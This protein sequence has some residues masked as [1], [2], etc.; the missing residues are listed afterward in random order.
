M[1]YI[2]TGGKASG[3]TSKIIEIYKEKK[4]YGFRSEKQ[5]ENGK[6]VGYNLVSMDNKVSYPFLSL[7]KVPDVN[8]MKFNFELSSISKVEE[9]FEKNFD[10]FDNLYLD[11]IGS[12]ELEYKGFYNLLIKL[13]SKKE[14]NIY[15]TVNKH[16]IEKL[17]E[18]LI[19]K[20]LE[21]K[22]IELV[23]LSA[24]IMAS[25]ES[26]RFGSE[27]KLLADYNGKTMF[28]LILEKVINSDIFSQVIV[29]TKYK[30]IIKIC[31]NY[32][33][34]FVINNNKAYLGI[35]ESVKL[36]VENSFSFIDGYM[37]ITADQ[38]KLSINS[39]KKLNFV[40]KNNKDKIIVSDFN[41]SIGSPNIFSKKFKKDLLSL[42]GDVGGK[43]I[44]KRNLDVIIKVPLDE[45]ENK[46]IDYKSDINNC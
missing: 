39:L 37:F 44:I 5:F 33:K 8:D 32:P 36:G 11:E 31:D 43:Q 7:K 45:N 4:G 19:N 14:K 26:K 18:I 15:L 16:N 12:L 46:D 30:E 41:G 27:N 23:S 40:F 20:N 9:D 3:K 6:L 25:G 38:P 17:V 34:I 13:I 1:L 22:L 21:Y 2:I 10:F 24:V 29:V 35:S 28:E 42:T